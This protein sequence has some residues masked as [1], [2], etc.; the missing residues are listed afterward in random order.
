MVCRYP[1]RS[2]G[3][4]LDGVGRTRTRINGMVCRSLPRSGGASLEGLEG[5]EMIACIYPPRSGGVS[6]E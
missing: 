6:P 4:S 3:A 5:H 2:G 1:P